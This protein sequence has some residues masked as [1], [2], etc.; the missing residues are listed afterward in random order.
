V[1][2]ILQS[3]DHLYRMHI[4]RAALTAVVAVS[5]FPYYGILGKQI[6]RKTHD[7][8]EHNHAWIESLRVPGSGTISNARTTLKT[9]TMHLTADHGVEL[10]AKIEFDLGH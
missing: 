2:H 4:L 6:I 1:H 10:L 9:V 5:A 7:R 3:D 8:L